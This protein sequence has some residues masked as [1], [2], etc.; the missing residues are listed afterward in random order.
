MRKIPGVKNERLSV[1]VS[2]S[3]RFASKVEISFS[4]AGGGEG[5]VTFRIS[6]VRRRMHLALSKASLL[7]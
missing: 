4:L 1:I 2:P 5:D 7:M 6:M 3:R